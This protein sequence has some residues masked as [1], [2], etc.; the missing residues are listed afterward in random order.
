M[1]QN[2]LWGLIAIINI[3]FLILPS[4]A[5]AEEA[6]LSFFKNKYRKQ[7]QMPYSPAPPNRAGIK[8]GLRLMG[9]GFMLMKNDI[10]DH[11]QGY[12]D[13][14]NDIPGSTVKSE[15]EPIKTGMDFSGEILISFNPYLG[16]GI[17]SGYISAGKESMQEVHLPQNTLEA[18]VYPKFSAIPVTLSLYFG[19]PVGRA[20]KIMFNAGGG[21]YMGK[22][23]WEKY[24]ITDSVHFYEETWSAKPEALGFHGG[25]HFEFGFTRN[26][27]FVIGAKG[28]YVKFKD[29]SG[30]LEWE[31]R[32]PLFGNETVSEENA[33]LW[34]GTWK[35]W[36][37]ANKYPGIIISE[38]PS[39][40]GWE[41]EREGEV[42]LSGIIF[43]AGLKINF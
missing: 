6:E 37:T 41:K 16:I 13:Y 4:P 38:D 1:T 35:T 12:N 7:A 18:T 15:F 30:N 5:S 11:L 10:N 19:I 42:N 28:R 32:S 26:S 9:G 36:L 17:G 8:V 33:K 22:I 43:Q 2:K 23:D 39:A 24:Q 27:A 14:F 25:L 3:V 34:Y 40:Y 29:I 31:R 21:Y 20:V